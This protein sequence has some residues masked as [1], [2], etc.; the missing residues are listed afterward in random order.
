MKNL[1]LL[2]ILTAALLISAACTST[3]PANANSTTT[4]TTTNTSN[5]A[6]RATTPMAT[7]TNTT[8]TTTTNTSNANSTASNTAEGAQDFTLVNKTG[9]V[10][11]KLFVS[12]HN[13]D[14]WQE[15]VLGQDTLGDGESLA[16]KFHRSEKAAMWDMKIEDTKGN[17]IEW[18]N[19]NLLEISK[20]T[21][22]YENGKATAETE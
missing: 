22:H 8:N 6:N 17:A 3:A 15:D 12:P 13:A 19:L 11:N 21:I 10:I 16:I 18:E 9:V 20:I 2:G 5:T 14:S 7:N 4:T 1:V